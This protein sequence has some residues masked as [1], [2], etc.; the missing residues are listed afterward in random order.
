MRR[1]T[2]NEKSIRC[3][4]SSEL[5]NRVVSAHSRD[6]EMN[7]KAQTGPQR[8]VVIFSQSPRLGCEGLIDLH[9][10]IRR[11]EWV[12]SE[13]TVNLGPVR[14]FERP[15]KRQRRFTQAH[16]Y[17]MHDVGGIQRIPCATMSSAQNT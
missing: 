7:R 3:E 11:A 15:S 9:G 12:S 1:L 2:L 10:L 5:I 6:S 14:P 8:P 16:S 4:I 17:T 13:H